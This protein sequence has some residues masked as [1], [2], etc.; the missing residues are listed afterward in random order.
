MSV[1]EYERDTVFLMIPE[2]HE[3]PPEALLPYVHT[4]RTGAAWEAFG[5]TPCEAVVG[6]DEEDQPYDDIDCCFLSV[7]GYTVEFALGGGLEEWDFGYALDGPPEARYLNSPMDVAVLIAGGVE[8]NTF[9]YTDASL[10]IS[11]KAEQ[12]LAAGDTEGFVRLMDAF[13]AEA[14]GRYGNQGFERKLAVIGED[15]PAV[16][17]LAGLAYFADDMDNAIYMNKAHGWVKQA[18]EA[19]DYPLLLHIATN[20]IEG[21]DDLLEERRTPCIYSGD[22]D[23]GFPFKESMKSYFL[24]RLGSTRGVLCDDLFTHNVDNSEELRGMLMLVCQYNP[25]KEARIEK[26]MRKHLR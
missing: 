7:D 22:S 25:K 21:I 4:A 24:E 2:N 3:P 18:V 17:V 11:V 10:K 1:P 15:D 8:P 26:L 23:R 9:Q 12:A 5:F 16:S 20:V 6:I 13:V 14:Q 19:Q